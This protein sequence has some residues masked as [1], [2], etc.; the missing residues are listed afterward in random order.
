MNN[1]SRLASDTQDL[2]SL[3]SVLQE[4]RAA[5]QTFFAAFAAEFKDW[6]PQNPRTT[7]VARAA[8]LCI[9]PVQLIANAYSTPVF[10]SSARFTCS[11]PFNVCPSKL[12]PVGDGHS[13]AHLSG[14]CHC[15]L[16]SLNGP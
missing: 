6:A 16:L 4:Q 15:T 3:A 2:G 13:T 5:L 1:C 9:P 8:Q 10:W 7:G 11:R 14:H 12:R